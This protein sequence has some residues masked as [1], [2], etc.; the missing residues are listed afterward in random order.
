MPED[1]EKHRFLSTILRGNL[2]AMAKGLGWFVREQI[3]VRLHD[4]SPPKPVQYKSTRLM[5]FDAAF[6]C[7]ISL[8]AS[9]GLGKGAAQGFGVVGKIAANRSGSPENRNNEPLKL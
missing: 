5:A 7:N 3:E 8:P 6:S 2:L 9:I 4:V 1:S